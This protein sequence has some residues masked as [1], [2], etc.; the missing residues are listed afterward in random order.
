MTLDYPH[1]TKSFDTIT[2]ISCRSGAVSAK[3]MTT[4][5]NLCYGRDSAS[6]EREA[7]NGHLALTSG[8]V[9]DGH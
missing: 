9:L 6:D 1:I 5:A 2:H 4:M 8:G 3:G 7:E